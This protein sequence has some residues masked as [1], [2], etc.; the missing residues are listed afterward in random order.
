MNVKVFNLK[1][2]VNETRFLVQH[3]LSDSKCRLNKDACNSKQKWNHNEC[4]CVCVCKK[5]DDQSSCRNDYVLNPSKCDF[6]SNKACKTGEYQDI[7]N[8]SCKNV[9]LVN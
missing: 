3:D 5:L 8:C 6:V 7:E 4:R 9:F 1:S 2:V